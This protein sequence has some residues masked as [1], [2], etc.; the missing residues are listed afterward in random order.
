VRDGCPRAATRAAPAT[1]FFHS[2]A[3]PG[4]DDPLPVPRLHVTP[5]PPEQER[6]RGVSARITIKGTR[7]PALAGG[8]LWPT[9]SQPWDADGTRDSSAPV[10]AASGGPQAKNMARVPRTR[11]RPL[12]GSAP[13]LLRPF[14]RL[15]RR[16]PHDVAT[17][18]AQTS[19]SALIL[20]P[21]G[22]GVEGVELGT[23]SLSEQHWSQRP[24]TPWSGVDI[25]SVFE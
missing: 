6:G 20:A 5:L 25:Q 14:P 2:F 17:A 22:A 7:K 18:V 9:A 3:S 12:R 15:A 1:R 19:P 13:L 23:V 8:I 21:M 16:G 24:G 4:K 11:C 10:G